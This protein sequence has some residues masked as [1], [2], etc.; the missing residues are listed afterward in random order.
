M[1]DDGTFTEVVK[2][3]LVTKTFQNT[4]SIAVKEAEMQT[5][6]QLVTQLSSVLSVVKKPMR[7]R[8][9]QIFTLYSAHA[10]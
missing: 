7:S 4:N 9:L 3:F 2:N 1:I 8:H 10:I 5:I 6:L